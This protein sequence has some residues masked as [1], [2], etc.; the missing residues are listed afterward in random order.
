MTLGLE[1]D[2]PLLR[3][4]NEDGETP[5]SL[6]LSRVGPM[7]S[8]MG[9]SGKSVALLGVADDNPH[10]SLGDTAGTRRVRLAIAETGPRGS[11]AIQDWQGWLSGR[12]TRSYTL[13]HTAVQRVALAACEVGCRTHVVGTGRLSSADFDDV[14]LS[15]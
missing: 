2:A 10:L 1:E 9:E 12:T 14:D 3:M 8:L 5:L 13:D 4:L 15:G 7:L 6:S 11:L